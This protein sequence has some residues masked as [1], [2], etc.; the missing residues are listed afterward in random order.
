MVPDSGGSYSGGRYILCGIGR[1][2]IHTNMHYLCI[3]GPLIIKL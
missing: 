2:Y 1:R 3:H